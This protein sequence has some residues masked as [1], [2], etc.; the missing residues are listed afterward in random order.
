[1]TLSEKL[2]PKILCNILFGDVSTLNSNHNQSV[3]KTTLDN[4]KTYYKRT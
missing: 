1:M 4:A 3:N 2:E